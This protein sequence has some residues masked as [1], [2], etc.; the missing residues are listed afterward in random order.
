ML[1]RVNFQ[2]PGLVKWNGE[3]SKYKTAIFKFLGG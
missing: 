1:D 3:S 2:D